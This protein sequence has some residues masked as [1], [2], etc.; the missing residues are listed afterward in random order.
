VI[1]GLI[2]VGKTSLCRL[3]KEKKNARLILEPADDNP[4]LAHFYSEQ[5]R[6][7]F[8]T[9]MFYL[10]SRSEQQLQLQQTQLFSD[11]F[12]A[13]YLFEKDQ[14]FAEHTLT[15]DE[16]ELYYQFSSL[17]A[18]QI[19]VPDFVLFLDAP[20]E[21]I[22]ERISNRAIEA[23]QQIRAS[24]LNELRARYYKLWRSYNKAPVYVLDTTLI[25][26][27][28]NP[29][30]AEYVL[31]MIEGWMNNTPLSGAPEAYHGQEDTQIPLFSLI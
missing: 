28:N 23:E 14:L 11:L 21:V 6:F 29:E 24:Y 13:D 1:E 25:D 10:A 19:A 3:L 31:K 27:I 26:Y 30:H 20:T 2:G 16:L 5:E 17:L 9:Q 7:A 18:R 12:V 4:F 8:P 22:Q 15:G